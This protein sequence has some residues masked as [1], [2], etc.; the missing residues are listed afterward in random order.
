MNIAIIGYGGM[1]KDIEKIALGKG[2][3]VKSI[4]DPVAKGATHK[5]INEDSLKEVDVAIDFTQPDTAV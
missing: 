5:E 4:I 1:G 2:I 3:T